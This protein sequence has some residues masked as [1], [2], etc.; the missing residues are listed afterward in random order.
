MNQTV[1]L[2][3]EKDLLAMLYPLQEILRFAQDDAARL[4]MTL[5]RAA[6]SRPFGGC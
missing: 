5:H 3:E 4:S 6:G 1:I 2:S